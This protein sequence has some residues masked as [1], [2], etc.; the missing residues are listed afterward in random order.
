V[1]TTALVESEGHDRDSLALPGKQDALVEAVIAANPNTIVVVNAGS[2]VEMPWRNNAA[3]VLL[4][5]FPG[6]EYGHALADVLFGLAEPGGRLPTTWPVAM[7]DVPVLDTNPK[8]GTLVYSESLNIGYRA[9]ATSNKAPAYEFGFGLGYTT[10]ELVDFSAPADVA[11]GEDFQVTVSI[12]NTGDRA[13]SDVVQ[14][15]ASRSDSSISRP[16]LWLCGFDR[17]SA[18]A[19]ETVTVTLKIKGRAFADW[20]S[21]W[22]YEAGAFTLSAA[23][24][25]KLDGAL[26]ASVSVN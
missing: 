10:W 25:V 17:V 22:N 12:K 14:I 21:G 20:A 19:G 24:S 15:Y 5:W 23:R 4:T 6:E 1:G 13:G 16:A 2:P 9:W 7:A 8:N 26:Y 18:A 11:P 3:A